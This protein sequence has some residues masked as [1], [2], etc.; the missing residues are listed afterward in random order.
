[1]TVTTAKPEVVTS[2][3]KL[4]LASDVY[5]FTLS[6]NGVVQSTFKQPITIKLPLKNTD[7]LDKELLSVGKLVYG[8]LQFQG[9][10]LDGISS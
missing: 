8:D 6:V 3:T 9:G 5:E 1:M 4:K 10:V 7:G 2:V